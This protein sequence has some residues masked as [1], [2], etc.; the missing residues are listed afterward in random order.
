MPTRPIA[1]ISFRHRLIAA[2]I[3]AGV[4]IAFAQNSRPA[5]AQQGTGQTKKTD[6]PSERPGIPEPI[7]LT[8]DEWLTHAVFDRLRLSVDDV[9]DRV[10]LVKKNDKD[11]NGKLDKPEW[12][13]GMPYFFESFDWNSD[14]FVDDRELLGLILDVEPLDER[15]MPKPAPGAPADAKIRVILATGEHLEFE[16]Q[17]SRI[18]DVKYFEDMLL[19]Q[20]RKALQKSDTD[21]AFE[22][23][24]LVAERQAQWRGLDETLKEFWLREAK[25]RMAKLEYERAL[26]LLHEMKQYCDRL[27][28][29]EHPD[30]ATETGFALKGAVEGLFGNKQYLLARHRLLTIA[31]DY[32]N[33]PTVKQMYDRFIQGTEAD[34]GAERYRQQARQKES[35][36]QNREACNLII[37]AASMWPSLP[38]LEA[39][40]KRIFAKY[41]ILHVGVRELPE[42]FSPWAP[43]GTPDTRVAQLMHIPLM[44]VSGVGEKTVYSSRILSD[45]ESS[46]LGRRLTLRV[47][48]GLL[49]SDGEKPITAHDVA[50]SISIRSD[51]KIPNHDAALASVLKEVRVTSPSEVVSDLNQI[52]L[53]AQSNF[54]FNVAAGHRLQ[55]DRLDQ[56]T[57]VGAGPF[58]LLDKKTGV[59]VSLEA[60]K[61]FFAG[62]PKIAEIV[63]RKYGNGKDAVKALL[64]GELTLLEH[65]PHADLKRIEAH[66]DELTLVRGAVPALH[67]ISFDFKARAELQNWALRRALVYAIDRQAILEGPLLNGPAREGDE[68]VNGPFPRGSFAFLPDLQYWPHDPVLAK[69]LA[70]AAK[71]ELRVQNLK[72]TMQHPDTEEATEACKF[73]KEYWRNILKVDVDLVARPTQQL[74]EEVALGRR[75]ELVYRV[76]YVRDPVLDAARVLCLGPPIAPDGAVMPN[77]ATAWLRKNLRE[78][79]FA[80]GWPLAREKLELLQHQARDDVALIPLW[81]LTD[82]YAFNN[83]LKGVADNSIGIYQDAEKWQVEPWYRKDTEK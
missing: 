5:L 64:T 4:A 60:N 37:Q 57:T 39:D 44:E 15:P 3:A 28:I 67:A 62:T 41:P 25:A 40:F 46:E 43:P 45:I 23:I 13:D 48:P 8:D 76:H 34:P 72:F 53:R 20:G 42:R 83:R 82:Y 30:A 58:R 63:E 26:D 56:N 75:F 77:A 24:N 10:N 65:V 78:L 6:D 54:L 9:P 27:G 7:K 38:G 52:P 50:R 74:E 61:H 80:T 71:K 29:A 33:H 17:R 55:G 14:G 18:V 47:K 73:I 22:I 68:L 66:P 51:K 36:G 79:A 59:E 70:D 11:A 69:G 35:A 16:V 19:E 21:K 81:Q 12:P 2:A 1:T 31:K 32:P 49:W